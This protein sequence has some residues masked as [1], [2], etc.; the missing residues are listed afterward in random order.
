MNKEYKEKSELASNNTT[1]MSAHILIAL[2]Y[3]VTFIGEAVLGNRSVAYA[4]LVTLLALISPA[5]EIAYWRKD[6]ENIMIKHLVASGFAVLYT[7]VMFTTT[8]AMIY[9]YVI[10]MILAISVYNDSKYAIK[11]NIGVILV[12]LISVVGGEITGKLGYV[13]KGSGMIQMTVIILACLMS[14][15]VV[16]RLNKN[17]QARIAEAAEAKNEAE[18]LM[19]EES[20]I[21]DTMRQGVSYMYSSTEQLLESAEKTKE[22]M[23]ELTHG[24]TDTANAVQTQTLQTEEIQK[25]VA[26]VDQE[27]SDIS[28]NMAH[29]LEILE[30]GSKEVSV[31]VTEVEESVQKGAYITEKLETLDKYIEEM[32]T[33]VELIS[34][35][36]SQT[37]LLALN[38][39]IEAARAGEAGRGFSVVATEISN[40]ASQTT[41]ATV[42]I[43]TLI[44]N[45]SGAISDV[46]NNTR[47][48][49][50]GISTEKVSTKNTAD[51]FKH[52]ES[53]TF[54]I[55]DNVDKLTEHIKKLEKANKEI[56]DSVY[57]ISAISQEVSAHSNETFEA[58]E[59]NVDILENIA[60]K[61]REL[62]DKIESK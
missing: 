13:D 5:M 44:D 28:D 7:F 41:E 46:V 60:V 25:K 26:L 58:E 10:P 43:T 30:K 45:V 9:V 48:M 23:K 57:T 24:A 29:T 40:M 55:R 56:V 14:Y 2:V 17:S 8:N 61:A 51:S 21:A 38:A 22:A 53:N 54:A 33:I 11:I 20:E 37:S 18:R 34:G 62:I 59:S 32:N 27:A 3:A 15:F 19:K 52:I 36:A 31:L 16:N 47:Q 4:I 6:P 42:S 1:A 50:D 35:I 12:N 49:I 39:S